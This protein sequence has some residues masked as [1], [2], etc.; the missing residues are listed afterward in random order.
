M[1]NLWGDLEVTKFIDARGKLTREDVKQLL[2]KE[3]ECDKQF[4]VQYWPIFLL[5]TNEHIGCCGLR[6]YDLA[7]RIYEIGAHI[8]PQHWKKWLR[9]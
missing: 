4:N 3:I 7:E 8:L 1:F 6:P 2:S 5:N 9:V